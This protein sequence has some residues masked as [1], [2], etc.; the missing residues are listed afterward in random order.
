M[1]QPLLHAARAVRAPS[2]MFGDR[3]G[4][5]CAPDAVPRMSESVRSRRRL[6]TSRGPVWTRACTLLL[7]VV[8]ERTRHRPVRTGLEG[9]GSASCHNTTAPC[10]WSADGVRFGLEF[11]WEYSPD[12]D[13]PA[14]DLPVRLTTAHT[15]SIHSPAL[16][17]RFNSAVIPSVI[18]RDV[19]G[20]NLRPEGFQDREEAFLC[21]KQARI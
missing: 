6:I 13:G 4:D 7:H 12:P 8:R 10:G 16:R 3:D 15:E 2:T 14:D 5:I 1:S 21:D 11:G 20:R 19:P 18:R 17:P 9:L